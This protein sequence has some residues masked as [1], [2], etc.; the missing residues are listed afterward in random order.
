MADFETYINIE[1][2]KTPI[3]ETTFNQLQDLIKKDIRKQ[4]ADAQLEGLKKAFPIGQ[5][6]ITQSATTNPATLL[7][8]GTWERVKGRVIVGV[9]EDVEQFNVV[10]KQVGELE[11]KLTIEEIASHEH[12]D[13]V[14]AIPTSATAGGYTCFVVENATNIEHATKKTG[15]DQPHNNIQPTE[16]VGYMWKRVS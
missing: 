10:G 1:D 11:H 16:V 9:D 6:Y 2:N 7:G 4:V 13:Y 15:G 3:S 8:F 5:T 12:T 14:N